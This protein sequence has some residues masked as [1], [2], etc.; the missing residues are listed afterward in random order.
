VPRMIVQCS[1]SMAGTPASIV[2]WPRVP[3]TTGSACRTSRAVSWVR[4]AGAVGPQPHR[5]G[6]GHAYFWVATICFWILS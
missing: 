4:W 3:G 6:C 5:S 2:P 1:Q